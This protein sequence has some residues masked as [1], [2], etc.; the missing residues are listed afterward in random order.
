[1]YLIKNYGTGGSAQ[2]EEVVGTLS[3]DTFYQI[4]NVTF[5]F[6]S[7][8][9]K[10]IGTL[11]DDYVEIAIRF[12]LNTTFDI[13]VTD[14]VLT[15]GNVTITAFP[16]QTNA[17]MLARSIAGWMPTPAENGADL[18]LPVVLTKEGMKYDDSAI[19]DIVAKNNIDYFDG[20]ISTKSNEL[21]AYGDTYKTS[22]YSPLGIPYS[23]YQ[24]KLYNTT[25][26][27]PIYGSGPAFVDTYVNTTVSNALRITTN[28]PG[29]ASGASDVS[30]TIVF[31][32]I[33]T[34][35]NYGVLA[36][37]YQATSILVVDDGYG[38]APA[39]ANAHTSGFTITTVTNN[40]LVRQSFTITGITSASALAT[41][42]TAK[43]FTF[44]NSA[45]GSYYVWFQVTSETDPAPGGTGIKVN[46][47]STDDA[48]EVTRIIRE[49][50]SGYQITKGVV[51][52]G[53]AIPAGSYF[54]FSS[55]TVNYVAWFKVSGSGNNPNVPGRIAIQINIESTDTNA[56]VTDKIRITLN[57]EYFATPN[58]RGLFLRGIDTSNINDPGKRYGILSTSFGPELGTFELDEFSSHTHTGA[59]QNVRLFPVGSSGSGDFWQNFGGS[60]LPVSISSTGSSETRPV[61][62]GVIWA[63]K[64]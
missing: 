14:A 17:D 52:A 31:S 59:A 10:T 23:R 3:F 8:T 18:Y 19:G 1:M 7:N 51:P 26:K 60:T 24:S 47:T 12:P 63:V 40:A 36:Y 46:L 55:P 56:Q 20:S 64:Y 2:T 33:H 6:G 16:D 9:D 11:N 57:S 5:P 45:S 38:A 22:D 49:T 21:L 4:N 61:N 48:T 29:S 39:N 13:T 43:Y 44:T 28:T 41:G 53:S 37:V 25:L 42:G 54:T 35:A 50:V 62:A 32:N 30:T 27:A 58:L 34:G 15:H